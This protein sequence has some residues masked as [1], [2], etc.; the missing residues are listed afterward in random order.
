MGDH[1]LVGLR[2]VALEALVTVFKTQVDALLGVPVSALRL[3]L[4]L[5]HMHVRPAPEDTQHGQVRPGPVECFIGCLVLEMGRGRCIGDADEEGEGL[6]PASTREL[7]L[8]KHG[9]DALFQSPVEPLRDAVLLRGVHS[10]LLMHDALLLEVG[11]PLLADEFT[12]LVSSEALE[13][14]S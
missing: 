3:P 7:G 2:I 14:T 8:S 13:M 11:V 6:A 4:L 12:T 5:L 9:G 1:E 10:G